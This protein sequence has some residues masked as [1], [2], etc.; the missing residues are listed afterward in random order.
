VSATKD[1]PRSALG[2]LN[3]AANILENEYRWS[4]CNKEGQEFPE[5]LNMYEITFSCSNEVYEEILREFDETAMAY[6]AQRPYT[7]TYDG[8]AVGCTA[9]WLIKTEKGLSNTVELVHAVLEK[10]SGTI[11]FSKTRNMCQ[12]RVLQKEAEKG[13]VDVSKPDDLF[14]DDYDTKLT[15]KLSKKLKKSKTIK[16]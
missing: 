15:K 8:D 3:N 16:V 13:A 1:A 7:V 5:V 9:I 4:T 2:A 6:T 12:R 14:F 11:L 10:Y